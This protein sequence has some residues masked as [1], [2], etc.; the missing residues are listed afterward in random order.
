MKAIMSLIKKEIYDYEEDTEEV[1]DEF[2]PIVLLRPT[3]RDSPNPRRNKRRNGK[4]N[5]KCD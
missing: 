3:G 5:K 2:F 4:S 1:S